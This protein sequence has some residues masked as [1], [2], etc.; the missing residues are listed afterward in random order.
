MCIRDRRTTID[1]HFFFKK[2]PAAI[3]V[4]SRDKID[5]ALAAANMALMAEA[6]GLGVLYS[7]FFCM[8]AGLSRP[9]VSYTHLDVYK[10]QGSSR[11]HP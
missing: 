3:V 6:C 1:D 11:W 2:A 7:G 9:P 5:G 4:V 8:A 10:R